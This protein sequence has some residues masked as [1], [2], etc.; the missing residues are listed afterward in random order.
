MQRLNLN[1]TGI[2]CDLELDLPH[3]YIHIIKVYMLQ[4]YDENKRQMSKYLKII[5]TI[6]YYQSIL[7][8]FNQPCH[9][10]PSEQLHSGRSQG[11][12]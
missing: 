12:G 4:L 9:L 6:Y 2:S 11:S 8:I 5:L 3:E 10:M 1:N 7:S